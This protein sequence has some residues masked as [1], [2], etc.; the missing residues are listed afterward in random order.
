MNVAIKIWNEMFY[1]YVRETIYL[2]EMAN[3]L[4]GMDIASNG[5]VVSFQGFNS[6][7][8]ALVEELLKKICEF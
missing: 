2:A 8:P 5:I 4:S 3:L 1:N 7:M 6:S